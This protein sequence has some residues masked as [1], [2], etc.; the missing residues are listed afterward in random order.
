MT[1]PHAVS[2]DAPGDVSDDDLLSIIEVAKRFNLH[3]KTVYRQLAEG[4]FPCH[5]T[6]LGKQWRISRASVEDFLSA[7]PVGAES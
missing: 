4:S 1:T 6:K 2:S 7:I 3:P 5:A